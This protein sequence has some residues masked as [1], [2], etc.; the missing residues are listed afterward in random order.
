MTQYPI[1]AALK[2]R[3]SSLLAD[4]SYDDDAFLSDLTTA[5]T[6]AICELEQ[7]LGILSDTVET[8]SDGCSAKSN[9]SDM[10]PTNFVN[11]HNFPELWVQGTDKSQSAL[12]LVAEACGVSPGRS[13]Q[14]RLV[15][16]PSLHVFISDT[17]IGNLAKYS[18]TMQKYLEHGSIETIGKLFYWK[19]KRRWHVVLGGE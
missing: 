10:Q 7:R 1:T 19:A 9:A 14:I 6:Q 16:T 12:E 17:F 4:H 18:I 2:E 13:Q 8:Q 15:I 5:F 3:I 11:A